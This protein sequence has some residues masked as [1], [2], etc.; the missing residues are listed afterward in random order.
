MPAQCAQRL[1][2]QT[3]KFFTLN[4]VA[5]LVGALLAMVYLIGAG[6]IQF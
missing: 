4:L 5:G 2:G 1:R 3:M 6:D